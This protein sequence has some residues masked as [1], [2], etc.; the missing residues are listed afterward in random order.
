MRNP[1]DHATEE[2]TLAALAKE[3]SNEKK[4]RALLESWVWR[5]GPIC[6]HC[7]S[8]RVFRLKAQKSSR[9]GVREGVLKC[10]DCRKQFTV[11]VGTIFEKTKVPISKWMMAVFILC[12]SK[13]SIS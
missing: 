6:C 2:I 4:A 9:C 3:Y 10:Q 5:D 8:K 12:G 11:T 1:S 7:Q 13:K